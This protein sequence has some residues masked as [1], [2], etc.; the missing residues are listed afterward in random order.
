MRSHRMTRRDVLRWSVGG[1][2]LAVLQPGARADAD[3]KVLT[4]GTSLDIKTLDP[5]RTNEKAVN[6]VNHV[7]YDTLV[8]FQGE[9]LKTI[10]PRL[11]TRWTVLPDGRTYTFTLRP[12]LR[13][14]TG[15]PLTSAD[16]K[17][18]FD[19]LIAINGPG[20]FTLSGVD[21]VEAPDPLT[22]VLRLKDPKP[23][24]LAILTD[25]VLSP[26]DTKLVMAHGGDASSSDKAE[27][28]LNQNSAGSGPYVMTE[29][30][31]RQ[32]L[33]LVRNPHYW[34]GSAH[35]DR[36]VMRS[37]TEPTDQAVMV[38][39][40][41]LDIA[42]NIGR[43]EAES[44]GHD[45]AVVVKASLNLNN[46]CVAMNNNP[47]VGG[48]FSNPKVQ[49]AVRYA[50]DYD[51]I[52][53]IADPGAIRAA[54]VI[55]TTLPGARPTREA[56]KMDRARATASLREANLG[57]VTGTF[58]FSPQQSGYGADT[59]LLSQKIQQDL[60]AVGIKVTLNGLPYAEWIDQERAAK[61]QF[62]LM[63]WNA[64]YMD[65]SDYLL[66]LPGLTVGKRFGWMPDTPQ[67]QDTLKIGQMAGSEPNATKR[68]ALYQDA[69]R[70]MSAGPFV[71]LYQ[72]SHLMAY[73]SNL[74]NVFWVTG[75]FVDFGPISRA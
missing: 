23:A 49:D 45:S 38:A 28:W 18:A 69:D 57:E 1:A 24:M 44:L 60:A 31:P 75:W 34:A 26:L 67:A 42:G 52:M 22:V 48:A 46:V 65:A 21:A 74:R 37:I 33:V 7:A 64:D 53:K 51:G 29:Y 30:T 66:F 63:G 39:K 12:N 61:M 17:W 11:A 32:Q 16:V 40:G 59:G 70:R 10:R 13:F 43:T 58:T 9:D 36:I 72:S 73:R 47:Q 55:P 62:G 20:A 8:T 25:P 19:R 56:I 4:V 50:L 6:S 14:A 68:L 41:D 3:E 54:G 35:F 27:A 71:P 2:A 15:N 5:G